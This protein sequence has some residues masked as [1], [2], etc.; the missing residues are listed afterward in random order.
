MMCDFLCENLNFLDE[1]LD[2]LYEYITDFFYE[3]SL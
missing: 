1:N 2:F 3:K